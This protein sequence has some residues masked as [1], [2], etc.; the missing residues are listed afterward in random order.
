[1]ALLPIPTEAERILLDRLALARHE[2]ATLRCMQA[3][4]WEREKA[5]DQVIRDLRRELLAAHDIV[6]CAEGM[7]MTTT[8]APFPRT[9]DFGGDRRRIGG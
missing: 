5:Q 9:H 1:M 3:A 8:P 6:G 4:S 7:V 2:I